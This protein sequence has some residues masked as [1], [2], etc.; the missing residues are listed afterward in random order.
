MGVRRSL[1]LVCYAKFEES[2]TFEVKAVF[3]LDAPAGPVCSPDQACP[4][5]LMVITIDVTVNAG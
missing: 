1:P 3:V 2:V 5:Y 4:A